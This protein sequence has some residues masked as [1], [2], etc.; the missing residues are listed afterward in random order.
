[1]PDNEAD[2]TE[3]LSEATD[4]AFVVGFNASAPD[5][6]KIVETEESK[7]DCKCP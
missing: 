7:Y 4:R 2:F 5:C 1:M 6:P 3:M